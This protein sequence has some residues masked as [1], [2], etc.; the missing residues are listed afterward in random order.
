MRFFSTLLLVVSLADIVGATPPA[1]MPAA[2]VSRWIAFFDKLVETVVG[3]DATCDKLATEVNGV[4]DRHRDVLILARNARAEGRKLP[5]SAQQ[6]MLA[7]A[8]R[9]V[10]ALHKCGQHDKVRAAFAKLDLNRR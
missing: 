9:M 7:G 6:H 10:P 5:Q 3:N 4:V 8:Q 1:E 2:D